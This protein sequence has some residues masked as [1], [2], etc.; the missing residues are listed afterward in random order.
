MGHVQLIKHEVDTVVIG[1]GIAGI[2]AAYYLSKQR[3]KSD[4]TIVDPLQAM[5]FTS[6]QSGDNYRNWWPH[7]TMVEFTSHS[8]GLMEQI[9]RESGNRLQMN[10]RG[11]A[12][13]T[14]K[15]SIDELLSQLY[16]G[17]ADDAESMIRIH[18]GSSTPNYQPPLSSNW[19]NAPDGVDVL[20]H[21]KLIRRTFPTFSEDIANVL[22][23][24]R[25]GDISGQQL[26]EYMLGAIRSRGGKLLR[27]KVSSVDHGDAFQLQLDNGESIRAECLINA[28][29]PF[30]DHVAAMLGVSLPVHNILQQKIAFEDRE[31][32]IPRDMP[33]SIDLDARTLDWTEEERE[34]LADHPETAWLTAPI[35]GGIH[36]RPDGGDHGSWLKLGWAYNHQTSK[37]RWEPDFDP[38]FPEIV[39]RGAAA[40]NPALETYYERLPA[41]THHYGGYYTMTEENWPLIGPMGRDGTFVVGAL[42]GFGTMAACAAGSLCSHW[43]TG[44][45]LPDYARDL[46]LD[47]YQDKGLMAFLQ[48]SSNRGVL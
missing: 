47:R 3:N 41:S 34:L 28:A 25:A 7:P 6:A 5:A 40:L 17:Y 27:A 31:K 1:A 15:D 43:V 30:V 2:A 39:L 18:C 44:S 14:R 33:F 4:V 13:A 20:C 37:A 8:T 16:E 10:R 29:G 12:L 36:C 19:Q 21:R 45:T 9:A 23:I 26:G 11:Y 46:S 35:H 24:R 32:V 38:Q 42:S 22:H 48:N